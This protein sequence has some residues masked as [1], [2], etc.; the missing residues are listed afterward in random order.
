MT[1]ES[2]HGITGEFVIYSKFKNWQLYNEIVFDLDQQ[3]SIREAI[4]E[5]E[6]IAFNA[7]VNS[8]K[9]AVN[10]LEELSF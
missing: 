9:E 2:F 10:S 8:A 6:V 3:K 7:G 1:V 5:A 4:R